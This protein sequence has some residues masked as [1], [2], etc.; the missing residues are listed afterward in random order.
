MIHFTLFTFQMYS[1]LL[2][3]HQ[4]EHQNHSNGMNEHK[5]IEG[6]QT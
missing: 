3:F 6:D 2:R 1:S 4:K 5:N